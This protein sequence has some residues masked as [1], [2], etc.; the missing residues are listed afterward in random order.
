MLWICL[1]LAADDRFC[2]RSV[3]EMDRVGPG[4]PREKGLNRQEVLEVI[5][6]TLAVWSYVSEGSNQ[7]GLDS[8]GPRRLPTDEL[9]APRS[10]P[11]G[12]GSL[13]RCLAVALRSNGGGWPHAE[14][15]TYQHSKGLGSAPAWRSFGALRDG[16]DEVAEI[17]GWGAWRAMVT[18]RMKDGSGK[19]TFKWVVED[20][21]CP[22]V[23]FT[24]SGASKMPTATLQNRAARHRSAGLIGKKGAGKTPAGTGVG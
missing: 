4:R 17:T 14:G 23:S 22:S 15:K 24:F 13:H 8:D 11:C 20:T 9:P 10:L 7:R 12:S 1:S 6:L 16:D 19:R 21:E 2:C 3:G 5:A 18:L